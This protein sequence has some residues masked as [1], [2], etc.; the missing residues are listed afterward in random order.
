VCCSALQCVAVCCSVLQCVA[1]CCSVLQCVAVCCSVLQCVASYPDPWDSHSRRTSCQLQLI[2]MKTIKKHPIEYGKSPIHPQK[3][4][5][6][7]PKSSIYPQKSRMCPKRAT[8]ICQKSP[9]RYQVITSLQQFLHLWKSPTRYSKIALYV[10]KR[11]LY[12]RKRALYLRKEKVNICK[13]ATY[14][15]A[16]APYTIPRNCL[17]AAILISVKEF[18]R[19]VHTHTYT[20][21]HTHDT[22]RLPRCSNP[23]ICEKEFYRIMHAHTYTRTHTYMFIHIDHIRDRAF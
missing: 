8:Y 23:Y 7:P 18:Y 17:A 15:R 2:T 16:K 14:I 22:E 6:Y 11:A 12:I 5:V 19:I 1:V 4:P 13:R 3:S 9:V 21:T 10:C 20:Q